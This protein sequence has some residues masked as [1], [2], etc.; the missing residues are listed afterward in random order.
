M[1][2][3]CNASH[4]LAAWAGCVYCRDGWTVSLPGVFQPSRDCPGLMRQPSPCPA[5]RVE[6]LHARVVLRAVH[7][8]RCRVRCRMFGMLCRQLH[9]SMFCLEE[10]DAGLGAS[11]AGH[12]PAQYATCH[13]V[14]QRGRVPLEYQTLRHGKKDWTRWAHFQPSHVPSASGC[15]EYTCVT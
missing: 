15:S 1:E 7:T 8:R 14:L 12:L 4:A 6:C 5:L 10:Y 2:C 13:F 9:A 3:A 11:C